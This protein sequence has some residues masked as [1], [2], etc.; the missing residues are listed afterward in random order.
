M[1]KDKDGNFTGMKNGIAIV[2]KH[3]F[4]GETWVTIWVNDGIHV[5]VKDAVALHREIVSLIDMGYSIE[6]Y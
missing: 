1:E 6:W 2:A 5:M 4:R 3:W